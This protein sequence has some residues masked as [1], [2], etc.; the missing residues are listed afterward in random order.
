LTED[1]DII[2]YCKETLQGRNGKLTHYRICDMYPPY[3]YVIVKG[4]IWPNL[5]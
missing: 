2:F 3:H 4:T 5:I 1:L